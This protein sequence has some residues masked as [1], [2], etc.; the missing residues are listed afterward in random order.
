MEKNSTTINLN[1]NKQFNTNSFLQQKKLFPTRKFD[2]YGFFK[3][4]YASFHKNLPDDEL[5][6][7]H[8][9]ELF[10]FILTL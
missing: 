2:A 10:N 8:M 1:L 4:E 9:N 6:K 7:V 5:E 3:A